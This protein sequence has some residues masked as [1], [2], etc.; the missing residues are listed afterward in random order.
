VEISKKANSFTFVRLMLSLVVMFGGVQSYL[1]G[2]F[3]LRVGKISAPTLAVYS[4]L[5]SVDI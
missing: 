3:F 1:G 5:Q 2:E 4:F